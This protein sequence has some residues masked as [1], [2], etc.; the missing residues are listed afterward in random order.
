MFE[1]LFR[2][3]SALNP[4]LNGPLS[5]ER[6]VFCVIEQ[7]RALVVT[8]CVSWPIICWLAWSICDWPNV[9]TS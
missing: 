4:H 3:P 2:F 1:Q 7:K 6:R 5:E 8:G 9:R